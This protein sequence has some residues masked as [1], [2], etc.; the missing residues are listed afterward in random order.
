MKYCV[1]I[2]NLISKDGLEVIKGSIE[3]TRENVV[4]WIATPKK[5]GNV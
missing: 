4:F 3:K 5:G 1:H 2:L